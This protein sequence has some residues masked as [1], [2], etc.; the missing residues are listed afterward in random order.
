MVFLVRV[1]KKLQRWL[2]PGWAKIG[3]EHPGAHVFDHSD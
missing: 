3:H 1:L 2:V